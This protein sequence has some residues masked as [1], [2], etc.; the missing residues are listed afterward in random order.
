VGKDTCPLCREIV[1]N[2]PPEM[3]RAAPNGSALTWDDTYNTFVFHPVRRELRRELFPF[4]LPN[5]TVL[6][7]VVERYQN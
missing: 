5:N 7:N 2:K 1:F 6:G 4:I 3:G